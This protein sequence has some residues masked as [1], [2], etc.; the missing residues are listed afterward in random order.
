MTVTEKL[1][2]RKMSVMDLAETLRNVSEA[3]RVMGVSR[4]H[5]Y[6]IREAYR[7]GG[8][9]ALR[10]E[11]RRKPNVKNR[12]RADIEAAV[13]KYAEEKP[14]WG[15]FRV[16][17]ELRVVEKLEISPAGVRCVWQRHNLETM[18]KRLARL[19]KQ[20][21]E[22]GRVL[23][24]TQLAALEK[25]Q[26]S[27]KDVVSSIET[28]HPGYLLAQDTFYVGYLKGVGRVYQQTMIDTYSSVAFAKLYTTK[29]SIT[30]ADA[31]NSR[32]LPFFEQHQVPVLRMLT[33][34]G[35]EFCGRDEH[36]AYEI[37]LGLEDIEHTRT[38]PYHPQ[39]NG[40]CERWHQTVL[41]EFYKVTFRKKI[42]GSLEALQ[43]DL[44]EYLVE[45]NHHR[46]HQGMRC[47]G[48]TPMQTFLEALPLVM[49]KQIPAAPM[50]A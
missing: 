46:T 30:A 35:T 16:A 22:E 31:L 28:H 19:E 5:F 21:A 1:V 23:T 3:C 32:A 43:L 7:R 44:D 45:Y 18:K 34:C 13:V 36:H 2:A 12:V 38:K 9:E 6:D 11:T 33:D 17:N 20:M 8:L 14:A 26:R 4:Q 29:S 15:Q 37:F 27:R 50:A 39:T 40:I 41:N 48:R 49:E 42:Y 24:E 25:V 10:E 47:L